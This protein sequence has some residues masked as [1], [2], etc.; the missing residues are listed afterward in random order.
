MATYVVSDIHGEYDLFAGLLE[1]IRLKEDDSL[2]I[3]GDI[4]D[5]GPHPIRTLLKVME[6]PNAICLAGNHELMAIECLEFLMTEITEKSI[7]ELDEKMVDNLLTWQYNGGRTTIQEF[8]AL[9]RKMQRLVIDFLKDFYIYEEMT[10]NDRDYLLVHA[11]LGGFYPGKEIEQYSLEE[12]I[13]SRAE[14]DIQYYEDI[15]VVTGHTPTQGIIGNPR[16]GYI[17]KKFNHIAIDCGCYRP[18]GRLA[19]VCL[20]TGEEFYFSD[21]Q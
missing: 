20:D 15:Y 21:D 6:M 19:A 11:G 8:C 16:P 4:R 13:W 2:Y 9:D 14:Y 1:K 10:V 7:E 5:R 12:L 17:F 3:L 18:D